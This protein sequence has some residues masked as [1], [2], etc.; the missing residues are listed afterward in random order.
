M[1]VQFDLTTSLLSLNDHVGNNLYHAH[2]GRCDCLQENCPI[3]ILAFYNWI[4]ILIFV[5][6]FIQHNTFLIGIKLT[7]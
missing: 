7:P 3:G 4:I 2:I 5:D 6:K 1:T